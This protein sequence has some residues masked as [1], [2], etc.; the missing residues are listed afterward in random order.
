MADLASTQTEPTHQIDHHDEVPVPK[1][2]II[3][4][5]LLMVAS[6][7]LVGLS[8]LSGIGQATAIEI[9]AEERFALVFTDGAPGTIEVSDPGTGTVIHAFDG[10]ENGFVRVALSA[11]VFDRK[12]AGIP[13]DSP[14]TLITTEGGPAYLI[15]PATGEFV[16]LGAFG[17]DN[18]HRFDP[19]IDA[20]RAAGLAQPPQP[21]TLKGAVE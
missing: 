18:G 15:D 13:P 3:A 7:L 21:I 19:L 5:G 11:L 12:R 4:V 16:A 6:V 1:A 10:T 8:Q 2:A 17:G 9:Q 14:Y 20:A